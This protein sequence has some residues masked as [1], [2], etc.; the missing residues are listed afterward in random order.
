M[1]A[2]ARQYVLWREGLAQIVGQH[3]KSHRGGRTDFRGVAEGQHDVDAGVDLR[4]PVGWLRY[5]EQR[6]DL[7][8]NHCQSTAVSQCLKEDIGSRLT[9]RPLGLLP[10][11]LWNERVDFAG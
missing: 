1:P 10:H 2:M 7:R 9:Q 8:E 11:P 3:S 5:T 4:V 6:I